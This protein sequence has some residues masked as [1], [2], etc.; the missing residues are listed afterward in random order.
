MPIFVGN[1]S[2]EGGKSAFRIKNSSNQSVLEQSVGTS[3][4]SFAYIMQRG[5]PGFETVFGT[6]HGLNPAVIA[7]S[8]G[9]N[10]VEI[11]C[12]KDLITQVKAP[13]KGISVVVCNVPNR[14]SNADT[15]KSIVD[16]LSSI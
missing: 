1:G 3:G 4:S 10:A 16:S 6:P 8:M 2:I 15:L 7:Q 11:N 14:E 5:T 12:L 9:I 13:I